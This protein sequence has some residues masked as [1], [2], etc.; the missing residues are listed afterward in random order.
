MTCAIQCWKDAHPGCPVAVNEFGLAVTAVGVDFK[1][2]LPHRFIAEELRLFESIGV[3]HAVWIWE[4][5]DEDYTE[6]EFDV[7]TNT[8]VLEALQENWK[9]NRN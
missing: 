4:V 1:P 6:R 9:L 7:R 5:Q 8:Q 2:R 3:N